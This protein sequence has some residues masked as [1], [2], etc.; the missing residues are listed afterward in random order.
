MV[1]IKI[2]LSM[3]NGIEM[4]FENTM[5]ENTFPWEKIVRNLLETAVLLLM[6]FCKGVR[7]GHLI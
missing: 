2:T 3:R 4:L 1:C 7:C 6:S 5:K